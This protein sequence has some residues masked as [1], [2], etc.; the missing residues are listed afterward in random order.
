M[1]DYKR[2]NLIKKFYKNCDL[3]TNFR[4]FCV[5]KE[6]STTSIGKMKFLKQ[7]TYIRYVLEKL[8]KFLQIITMTPQIL[9]H[10]RFL[11]NYKRPGTSAQA[12]FSTHFF[13]KKCSFA[14]FHKS[15]KLPSYSLKYV[16]SFM[17]G[18]LIT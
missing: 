11:K 13:D 7:G 18:N 1:S 16:W 5:C 15:T 8:S 6:L 10:G 2:K 9:V 12:T 4:L 17:L 14:I 3:K